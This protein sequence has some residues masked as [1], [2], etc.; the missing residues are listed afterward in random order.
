[1]KYISLIEYI[2][3]FFYIYFLMILATFI[4]PTFITNTILFI[5]CVI[6]TFNILI[7]CNFSNNNKN[8]KYIIVFLFT[9]IYSLFCVYCY[10]FFHIIIKK[11]IIP[12]QF[13]MIIPILYLIN[14]R[15]QENLFQCRNYHGIY[16]ILE[17]IKILL[18]K[19]II[20]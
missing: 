10:I 12:K 4:K 20:S 8:K 3:I 5:Y 13:L 2:F 19:Y 15:I 11:N 14:M 17:N 1:M 7:L 16:W 18:Y 6:T 9:L